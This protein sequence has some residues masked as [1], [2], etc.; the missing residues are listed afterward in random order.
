MKAIRILDST[1]Q[2]VLKYQGKDEQSTLAQVRYN[3]L[4]DVFTGLTTYHLQSHL[5]TAIKG[6]GQVEIDDLYIGIDSNGQGYILPVE[7]KSD[8][9]HDQLGVV[10]I[11]QMVRFARKNFPGLTVRPIGIKVFSDTFVFMEFTDTDDV[12]EV[13]TSEYRRYQLYREK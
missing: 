2:I 11:T 4:V 6:L 7:A 13:A 5:R 12:N 8:A 10:Q 3:R 9:P 1:P